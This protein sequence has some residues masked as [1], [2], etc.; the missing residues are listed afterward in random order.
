MSATIPLAQKLFSGS[1][2]SPLIVVSDCIEYRALPLLRYFV[3]STLRSRPQ[4]VVCAALFETTTEAFGKYF[5][6]ELRQ[7]IHARELLGDADVLASS[8]CIS[9]WASAVCKKNPSGGKGISQTADGNVIVIVDSVAPY[10]LRHPA[11]TLCMELVRVKAVA[12]VATTAVLA[13]RDLHSNAAL[14]CLHHV[15]T[16]RIHVEI[17]DDITVGATTTRVHRTVAE[18]HVTHLKQTRTAPTA[19]SKESS[20][21]SK[22]L[23]TETCTVAISSS[24]AVKFTHT[25]VGQNADSASNDVERTTDDAAPKIQPH[26][27]PYVLTDTQKRDILQGTSGGLISYQPDD[28]DDFDDED[29]DE[30]LDI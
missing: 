26:Q 10:L 9:Q 17:P 30:D 28:A 2:R 16:S 3:A 11:A 5:P 22:W 20:G 6:L 15:S 12:G 21:T 24:G 25:K 23:H 18:C 4:A 13:H 7:R 1:E 27:L 14:A 29:P 19:R 8:A